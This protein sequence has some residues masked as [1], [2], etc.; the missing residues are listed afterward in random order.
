[1][2]PGEP[3]SKKKGRQLLALAA[4]MFFFSVCLFVLGYADAAAGGRH[5]VKQEK[6]NPD[7]RKDAEIKG[8]KAAKEC[9]SHLE[10]LEKIGGIC[11]QERAGKSKESGKGNDTL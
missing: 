2:K 4:V 9:K 5:S 8:K 6:Y 7:S 3:K 1:M 10:I 11:Q